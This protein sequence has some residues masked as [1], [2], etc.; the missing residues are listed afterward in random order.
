M[1]EKTTLIATQRLVGAYG[2][3]EAGEAF[4]VTNPGHYTD[5]GLAEVAK[6]SPKS[7]KK[8][9]TEDEKILPD[10]VND[11]DG[12]YKRPAKKEDKDDTKTKEDKTDTATK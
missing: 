5:M 12:N 10:K 6:E 4:E 11:A 1:A 8:E 9:I 7:V 2:V 3:V